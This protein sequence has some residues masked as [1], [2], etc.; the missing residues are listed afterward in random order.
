MT[1]IN[2]LLVKSL[3]KIWHKLQRGSINQDGGSSF[4]NMGCSNYCLSIFTC[5]H[6]SHDISILWRRIIWNKNVV[7]HSSQMCCHMC[8]ICEP[9][10]Q[11]NDRLGEGIHFSYYKRASALHF[12]GRYHVSTCDEMC[13]IQLKGVTHIIK[14]RY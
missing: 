8:N 1:C 7:K 13:N 14:M 11:T 2:N 3:V 10:Q 4:V 5:M 12:Q 9:K 6:N